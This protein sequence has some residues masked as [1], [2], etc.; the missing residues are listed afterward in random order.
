MTGWGLRLEGKKGIR[1][2]SS[3]RPFPAAPFGQEMGRKEV[4]SLVTPR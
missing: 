1:G 2:A 4:K 3:V